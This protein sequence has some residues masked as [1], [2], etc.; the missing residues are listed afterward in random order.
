MGAGLFHALCVAVL[1][2]AVILLAARY[3]QALPEAEVIPPDRVEAAPAEMTL[4][5]FI[6]PKAGKPWYAVND[7]VMG[8]KSRSRLEMGDGYAVFT[9]D[10]SLKNFG[11]FASV[12]APIADGDLSAHDGLT[13]RV[14]GDGKK[15]KLFVK[16]NKPDNGLRY[17]ADI[18]PGDGEWR[19]IRVPFSELKPYWRGWRL[20]VWPKL[21]TGTIKSVGFMIADKQAG[22]FRL[23]IQW[24]KAY[25]EE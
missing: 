11:G 19:T 15:Y 5:N 13:V 6:D 10:V 23:D 25:G 2:A 8:G 21:S 14:R 17:Q 9:G 18:D 24:I 22:P 4:F 7:M 1:A 20:R 3:V 16:T 12:R